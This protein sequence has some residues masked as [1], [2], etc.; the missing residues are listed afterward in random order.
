MLGVRSLNESIDRIIPVHSQSLTSAP[1]NEGFQNESPFPGAVVPFPG[2][3][4][5]VKHDK[6]EGCIWLISRGCDMMWLT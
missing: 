6:L 1:E 2:A 3:D 5:Q 4:V